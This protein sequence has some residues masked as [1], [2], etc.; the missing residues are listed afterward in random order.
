MD[1]FY[2]ISALFWRFQNDLDQ[3]N[4]IGHGFDRHEMFVCLFSDGQAAMRGC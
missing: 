1:V 2:S 4:K 3:L